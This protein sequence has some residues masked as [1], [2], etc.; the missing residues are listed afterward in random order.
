ML[1]RDVARQVLHEDGLREPFTVKEVTKQIAFF[2][3]SD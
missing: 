3:N 2:A 1:H